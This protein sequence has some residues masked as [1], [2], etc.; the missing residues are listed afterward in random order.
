MLAKPKINFFKHLL[1]TEKH[2]REEI[3]QHKKTLSTSYKNKNVSNASIITIPDVL[4][5]ITHIIEENGFIL[6]TLNYPNI[7]NDRGAAFSLKLILRGPMTQISALLS[8]LSSN[9]WIA[10]VHDFSLE[11]DEHEM[12]NLEINIFVLLTALN[13][14]ENSVK[15]FK[16]LGF[17]QDANHFFALLRQPD[18]QIQIVQEGS[19]IGSEK[20]TS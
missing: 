15:Q 9:T 3:N 20:D 14:T 11:A 1:Y 16:L 12:T 17:L 18:G 13:A 6:Q 5:R 19:I 2:L 7:H 10:G 4:S 8:Q